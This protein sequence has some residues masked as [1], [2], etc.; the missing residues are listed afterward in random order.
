M[1]EGMPI[2]TAEVECPLLKQKRDVSFKVNV[3][4]GPDHGGLDV[5]ACSDFLEKSGQPNCGHG[6]VHGSTAHELYEAELK[7]HREEL[8]KIGPNVIG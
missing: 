1:N 2:H 7:K 6:C 5:S 3:F 8:S 4:R